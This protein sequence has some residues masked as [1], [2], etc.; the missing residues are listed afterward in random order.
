MKLNI[1]HE[2]KQPSFQRTIITARIFAQ[3]TSPSRQEVA[4]ALAEELS[5]K[6]DLL[7]VDQILP[8]YG[9]TSAT[10]KARVYTDEEVMR[11][12]ERENLIEK[13]KKVEAKAEETNEE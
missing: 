8:A 10:V 11:R 12:I 9:D 3:G 13:N 4:D 5:A 6:R 2:E 1:T 7:L